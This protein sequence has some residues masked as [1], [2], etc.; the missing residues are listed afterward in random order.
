MKNFYW[1]CSKISAKINVLSLTRPKNTNLEILFSKSWKT[2]KSSKYLL[3][4]FLLKYYLVSSLFFERLLVTHRLQTSIYLQKPSTR[5][6]LSEEWLR[7][8]T[9]AV[10]ENEQNWKINF[11]E[12]V[13]SDL[14]K[15]KFNNLSNKFSF[16]LRA[17]QKAFEKRFKANCHSWAASKLQ[18]TGKMSENELPFASPPQIRKQ[19]LN[20]APYKRNGHSTAQANKWT[21][22]CERST[23]S[24]LRPRGH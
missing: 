1:R 15:L 9:L 18:A 6:H 3:N 4:T 16:Q 14:V 24:S 22:S 10:V 2:T 19:K 7:R 17:A 23:G 21:A 8:S 13:Y 20:S 5:E 12:L 11:T